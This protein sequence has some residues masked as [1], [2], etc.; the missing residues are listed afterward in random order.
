MRDSNLLGVDSGLA[1]LNLSIDARDPYLY[2][3]TFKF[4]TISVFEIK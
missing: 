3:Y 1:R 2:C 4:N